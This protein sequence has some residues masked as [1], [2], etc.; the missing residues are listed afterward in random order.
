MTLTEKAAYIKG[1][2]ECMKLDT[3]S[4]EGKLLVAMADMLEDI[5]I[6]VADLEDTCAE[7]DEYIEEVDEDLGALEEELYGDECDCC[8]ECDDDEC[9]CCDGYHYQTE[10]PECGETVLLDDEILEDG[11]FE[12]PHCG[13]EIHFDDEEEECAE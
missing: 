7:L 11:A 1:M 3:E 12:C 8:D 13:E 4:N 10:C 9:D 2:L 5:A 6:S